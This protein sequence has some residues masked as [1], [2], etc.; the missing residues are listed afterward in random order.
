MKF[1][2]KKQKSYEDRSNISSKLKEQYQDRLP[3]IIELSIESAQEKKIH[4]IQAKFKQ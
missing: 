2:Y 3:V 1:Q 4:K